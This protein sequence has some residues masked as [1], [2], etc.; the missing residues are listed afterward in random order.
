MIF[1][2][3]GPDQLFVTNDHYIVH[4]G[5]KPIFTINAVISTNKADLI[6]NTGTYYIFR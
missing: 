4:L 1:C 2:M 3:C 5:H 6:L